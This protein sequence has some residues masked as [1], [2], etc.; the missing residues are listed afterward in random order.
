MKNT[1][2][3]KVTG[4]SL[5]FSVALAT[6]LS[7]FGSIKADGGCQRGPGPRCLYSPCSNGNTTCSKICTID[8]TEGFGACVYNG[9]SEDACYEWHA[10]NYPVWYYPGTCVNNTCVY[11]NPSVAYYFGP[12]SAGQRCGSGG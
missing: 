6:L 1:I 12:M 2:L 10:Q 9:N 4:G 3:L 8:Y 11:G 7:S 5:L